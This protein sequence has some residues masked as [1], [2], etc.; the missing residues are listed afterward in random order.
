M[1][2]VERCIVEI[3]GRKVR[4]TLHYGLD[5]VFRLGVLEHGRPVI[6]VQEELNSPETPLHLSDLR[7]RPNGVQDLGIDGFDVLSL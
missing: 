4:G 5:V 3:C 7:H 2:G 6:A 1:E